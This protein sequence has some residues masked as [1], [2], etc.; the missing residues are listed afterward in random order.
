[1]LE[2]RSLLALIIVILMFG[3]AKSRLRTPTM[4]QRG[5]ELT[6]GEMRVRLYDYLSLFASVV[7]STANEILENEEDSDIR[8]AALRWKINVIPAMQK[9]VFQTEPIAAWGDAWGL[10]VEMQLLF[11]EGARNKAF[12]DSQGLAVDA[13]KRLEAEVYRQVTAV[14]GSERAREVRV[15]MYNRARENPRMDLTFGRRSGMTAASLLTAR[16]LSGSGLSSVA[17]ID[18]TVRDLSD[19]FTIYIEQIPKEV[20]WN[21]ELLVLRLNRDIID[22]FKTDV[23]SMD[24]SLEGIHKALEEVPSLIGSERRLVLEDLDLKLAETLNAIDVQRIATVDVLQDERV[25]LLQEL[26]KQLETSLASLEQ[27]RVLLMSELQTLTAQSIEQGSQETKEL[28]DHL[29][30]RVLQLL[31][32]AVVLFALSSIFVRRIFGPRRP[33]GG[34]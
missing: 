8:E 22:P 10:T 20:R 15:E 1:M 6:T 14:V 33:A 21:S 25:I 26:N 11:E 29:F 31:L 16:E 24:R 5:I 23:E 7:Q 27:G 9:A 13:S 17:Q 32:V 19:R 12:G 2:K 18:E 4:E 34:S 28:V 30:W 3:C